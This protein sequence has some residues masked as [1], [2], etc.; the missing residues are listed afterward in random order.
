MIFIGGVHGVGKSYF[1]DRVK[2]KLGLNAYTASELIS[3][4][5]KEE[6]TSNKRVCEIDVNQDYLLEAIKILSTTES[7]FMLDGHFC[8]L[9]KNGE[10][11][12]IPLVTF[13]QLSPRAIIVLYDSMESIIERLNK[14]DG[15]DYE[16]SAIEVFQK[17]ELIYSQEVSQVLNVP[18]IAVNNKSFSDEVYHFIMTYK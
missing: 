18:Y 8:L 9:N 2:H 3:E 6:F 12:R 16:S 11:Q 10:V 7:E 4:R 13:T 1:C 5:K 17:E 15:I 14:R